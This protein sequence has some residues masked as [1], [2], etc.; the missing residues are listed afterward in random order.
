MNNVRLDGLMNEGKAL[1]FT[2]T[3]VTDLLYKNGAKET[4]NHLKAPQPDANR[5][6]HFQVSGSEGLC[7]NLDDVRR[8]CTKVKSISTLEDNIITVK[9]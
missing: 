8:F 1:N 2:N 4:I 5:M 7:I 6:V 9:G 3:F